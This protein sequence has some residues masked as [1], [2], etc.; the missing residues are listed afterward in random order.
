MNDRDIRNFLTASTFDRYGMAVD[1][2]LA[3]K[4]KVYFGGA[5]YQELRDL[6]A[7]ALETRSKRHLAPEIAPN[8]IFVPGVM[9]SLLMSSKMGGIWWIDART[10]KHIDDL[11]LAPGG[12]KDADPAVGLL[13]CAVDTTYEPFFAAINERGDFN[14]EIFAYDWR[15]PLELSAGALRDKVNETYANNG[16][17]RVHLVAHSMGG[18]MVRAALWRH[19][20]EM[21]PKIDRVIFLGTPHYGSAAIAGYLKNHLWGFEL[22]AL[23]GLY[24]SRDTF[25][26]LWGVLGMLPA[27]RGIYPGTRHND[28]EPWTGG[29]AGDP[30]VHPCANFDM[31]DAKEWNLGLSTEQT[32]QLQNALDHAAHFHR[33]L[34]E[35]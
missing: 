5:A 7:K 28:P 31:Y 27:P 12:Q 32:D 3:P 6:A 1:D 30:Y 11:K 19:G 16:S 20:A 35:S 17:E 22:M 9:G 14:H 15:K 33:E 25:R 10:R 29:K 21:W 4:L 18:L 26:S 23:L 8:L 2:R 13:S 24:L 34:Y